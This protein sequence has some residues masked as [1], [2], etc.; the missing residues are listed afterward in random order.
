MQMR[1]SCD[2]AA[3]TA[4]L[5]LCTASDRTAPTD[6]AGAWLELFGCGGGCAQANPYTGGCSCP[7]GTTAV[8]MDVEVSTSCGVT[9]AT[10]GLCV[11]T[12][13]PSATFGGAYQ[14][15][16]AGAPGCTGVNPRTGACSCPADATA[17]SMP[18]INDI[19]GGFTTAPIVLCSR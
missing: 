9:P 2:G 19:P 11:D 16:A 17:Q 5:S 12:T 4:S 6:Y 15:G 13:T 8:E 3:T 14:L 10:L 1:A 18:T 7:F